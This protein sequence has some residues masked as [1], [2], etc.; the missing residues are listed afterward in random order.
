MEE[1][2]K[3]ETPRCEFKGCLPHS[4]IPAYLLI[5][6][7]PSGPVVKWSCTGHRFSF[8]GNRSYAVAKFECFEEN[9]N[10]RRHELAAPLDIPEEATLREMTGEEERDFGESD[11]ETPTCVDPECLNPARRGEFCN[12]CQSRWEDEQHAKAASAEAEGRP[13]A[14]NRRRGF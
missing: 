9:R 1:K 2:N 13:R 11:E 5:W 10:P 3:R 8:G 4:A 12:E 14:I 6:N 7:L